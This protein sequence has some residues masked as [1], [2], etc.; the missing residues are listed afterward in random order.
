MYSKGTLQNR[1]GPESIQEKEPPLERK[2]KQWCSYKEPK[3]LPTKKKETQRTNGQRGNFE[4]P[5][6][7]PPSPES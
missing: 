6:T 4:M 7:K 1:R 5:S 2:R 3:L